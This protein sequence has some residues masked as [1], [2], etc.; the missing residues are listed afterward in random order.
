MEEF[1]PGLLAPAS[2]KLWR[3]APC[4]GQWGDVSSGA[5]CPGLIEA[6]GRLYSPQKV[7]WVSSGAACPG[8]IEA[9]TTRWGFAEG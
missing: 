8:L 9:E 7:Q 5:A 1:H 3:M 4:P 6:R 2:L